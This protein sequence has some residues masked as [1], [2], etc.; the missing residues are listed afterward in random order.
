MAVGVEDGAALIG[1]VLVDGHSVAELH[2]MVGPRRAF[3]LK[4]ETESVGSHE[5]S[6]GW[7]VAVE[8]HMVETEVL[9]RAEDSFP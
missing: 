3:G 1:K 5:S 7:A 2:A 6:F 9:A 4:V 8:T